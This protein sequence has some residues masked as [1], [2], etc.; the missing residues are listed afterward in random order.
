MSELP[1]SADPA[2]APAARILW[3]HPD[4]KQNPAPPTRKEVALSPYDVSSLG[5]SIPFVYFF[6][7]VLDGD[8]LV[9]TFDSLLRDWYPVLLGPSRIPAVLVPAIIYSSGPTTS[10]MELLDY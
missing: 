8:R 2:P 5:R 3:I 7:S 1:T 9:A 4:P 10:T 6:D